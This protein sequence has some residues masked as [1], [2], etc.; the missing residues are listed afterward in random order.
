MEP[1]RSSVVQI[2]HPHLDQ[3]SALRPLW[4][5]LQSIVITIWEFL[6]AFVLLFQFF[7]ILIKEERHAWSTTF[8]EKYVNHLKVWIEYTFWV[9]DDRP[10]IVEY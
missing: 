3:M 9:R 10:R 2:E 7:H 8:T 1:E 4:W 5:I 6:L